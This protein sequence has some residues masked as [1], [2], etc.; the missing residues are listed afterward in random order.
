MAFS[1]AIRTLV[2]PGDGSI[3]LNVGDGVV[4]DSTAEA[5]YDEAL[6]KARFAGAGVQA[7]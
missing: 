6:W 4:Q 3:R 1:V 7:R 5:E 2:L